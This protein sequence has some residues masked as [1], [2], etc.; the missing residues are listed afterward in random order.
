MQPVAALGKPLDER[1]REPRV[2]QPGRCLRQQP[3]QPARRGA[4]KAGITALGQQDE[5][6]EGVVDADPRQLRCLQVTVLGELSA[7]LLA[8]A[9][10]GAPQEL[11]IGAV[12]V[13]RRRGGWVY[14]VVG[15]R[16][17]RAASTM[18]PARPSGRARR[19]TR[20]VRRR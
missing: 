20:E 14:C 6:R 19:A 2:A 8:V 7:G 16:E 4:I 1:Q 15:G 13:K 5:D 9:G 18:S 17:G 10:Y 11:A 12:A 3:A